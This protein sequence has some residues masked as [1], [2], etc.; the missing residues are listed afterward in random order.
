MGKTEANASEPTLV[1]LL[2]R[3]ARQ[4]SDGRLVLDTASGLVVGSLALAFRPPAWP[5]VLSAAVSILAFGGWGISDRALRESA[6][7]SRRARTLRAVCI[8][9]ATLG[10][11]GF[12]ALAG[13][14]MALM[15][16]TWIS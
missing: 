4:A 11:L 5:V 10:A 14:V 9:M 8:A 6:A 13:T 16:G 1:S 2:V 3:R 15:L 12:L 7:G